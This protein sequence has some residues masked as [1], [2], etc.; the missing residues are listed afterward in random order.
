MKHTKLII[1]R[2]PSGAGKSTISKRLFES[3][4]RNTALIEQDQYRFMFSP[5]GGE[6]NSKTIHEMILQNTLTALRDGYDVILEGILNVRSY[7][8]TFETLIRE[9]PT[10]NYLFY[11]DVSFNE[12]IRR[13]R[14]RLAK[15]K[16]KFTEKDMEGWYKPRDITGYDCEHIISEQSSLEETVAKITQITQTQ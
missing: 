13:H 9:H 4:K 15:G 7:G 16:F 10:Q 2:G 11:F 6:L 3:A 5:P 1:L 12:T 14:T 8:K